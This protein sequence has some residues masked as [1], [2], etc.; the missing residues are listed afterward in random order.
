MVLGSRHRICRWVFAC[1]GLLAT[2]QA[3]SQA[4]NVTPEN[5]YKKRIQVSETIQPLGENPFGEQ[6]SLYNGALSFEQKDINAPGIGPDIDIIRSFSIPNVGINAAFHD[7]HANAF[8]DWALEVPHIETLSAPEKNVVNGIT[9]YQWFLIDDFYGTQRCSGLSAGPDMYVS[10]PGSVVTYNS[11]DWWH[12]YQLIIPG[13]GRQDLLWRDASNTLSPQMTAADGSTMSFPI[14]TKQHWSI[15]CLSQTANGQPGQGYLAVS[16]DGTKYW[17]DWLIYKSADLVVNQA[18]GGLKRRTLMMMVSKVQDRFGNTVNYSYDSNGNLTSIQASDGRQIALNYV[19]WQAPTSDPGPSNSPPTTYTSFRISSITLQP[20]SGAP[21]TWNYTYGSDPT[22]PRLTAAQLPDGV[23]VWSFN[24]SGLP[25]TE[26]DEVITYGGADTCQYTLTPNGG[27][28][29]TAVL[30]HPSGLVGTFTVKTVIRGRSYVPESCTGTSPGMRPRVYAESAIQQKAFSGAG[31]PNETWTYSYSPSNESWAKD[32]STGCASTV[33]TDVIDPNHNAAR[34]TFSNKFDATESLL[35]QTDYYSGAVGGT[36][37]R[38]EI[39]SYANPAGGPWPAMLGSS[40]QVVV[41]TAQMGQLIPI[42]QRTLQQDGDIYTW[43]AEAFDVYA[44]ATMTKRYNSIAGQGA[45]E[46][47]MSYLYDLPHWVLGLPQ[48]TDNV[49]T[50]EMESLN[51]YNLANVTLKSRARFGQTLMSYAFDGQGQLASFIDGK[52]HTTTLSNY[53]RGIPQSIGYPDNT[54]QSLVV[55]D[56]GQIS[57]I[58]DQAGNTTNYSYD[59][60]GRVT[61]ISYPANDTVSW[62]SKQFTYAPVATSER[63]ISGLHWDRTITIGNARTA[64][65]FDAM[66]RPV[67]SDI[68]IIGVSNSDITNTTAYDWKGKAT[69][70]SYPVVGA[71]DIGS[72]STGTH[73]AYDAL[74]RLI[75]T[76]EDSELGVLTTTT[77]YIANAGQQV[78]DPN[79]NVTT[80]YH[81]VFD[82]PSYQYPIQIN[83]AAGISQS[84]TRDIYGNPTA[85][86][87]SGVYGSEHDSITKTLMYDSYHRLCR[88]AEPES[89]SM[90]MAYDAANNLVWSAQGQSI[91]DGTCGQADVA[92]SAQTVRNYDA[93]NRVLTITPPSGTQSTTYFYDARG[94]IKTAV[95]GIATQSF[96]Y[97]TR[98]LLTSQTL[99]IAGTSSTWGV[100]YNYDGYA[101][102]NAIGYPISNGVS[103]GVAYNPDPLGRAT[104]VGSYVTGITY[105]PNGQVAGFNYSNG[106]SYVAQQNARRLL[107]NF[108]YGAGS[109][110]SVSEDFIYD[111]NGNITNVNDLV[112][113]QRTKVFGYDALNRLTSATATN[114]YGTESYTYDALN[115]L[116]SRLTGGNQLT[117]N[118]DASNRLA[119]VTQGA[120]VTTTYG[121]DASGNRNSLSSGSTITQYGFDAE[122]QLLQI[123]GLESYAYDS[124]GRRIVKTASSGTATYYFY[125]QAGQLMFQYEPATAKATNYIYLGTKSIARHASNNS[126]IIG[127]IDGISTDGSGNAT[128]VGWACSTNLA[129]STNVDLYIGG[130]VDGGGTFIGR[131]SASQASESGVAMACNVSGGSYRFAIPIST[132]IRSQYAGQAIYVYGISPVGNANLAIS[133]SGTNSVPANPAAPVAPSSVTTTVASDLTSVVATWPSVSAATSYS[134]QYRINSGAWTQNASL[135]A[136]SFILNSPADGN[137]QFQVQACNLGGC[138]IFA[139]STAVGVWH[140]TAAPA[141]SAPGISSNGSYTVSWVAVSAA[142]SYTLQQQTNGG[143]WTTIQTSNATS[144]AA[145]G[146]GTGSYAYRVQGCNG[147]GC[148]PWS[149]IVTTTV[150]YPP[151]SAPSVSVP[152]SSN[153]GSYAVNW[154]SVSGATSYTLQE[155]VNGGGW[156]TVQSSGATSWIASGKGNGTYGYRAQACNVGGCGPWSGTGSITVTYPPSGAPSVSALGSSTNGSYTVS[157]SGVGGANSYVLQEQVNSGGWSAVQNSGATSWSTSGKGNG[158]YGYHVQACNVGGCGPW[159]SV[160]NVGVTLIPATPTGGTATWVSGPYYKPVVKYS[161]NATAWATSYNVQESDPNSGGW[162]SFYSGTGTSASSLFLVNGNVYFQVRACS[163][164]G[165]SPWSASA[166]ITLSSGG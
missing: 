142:A 82:E 54:S 95:S 16:P 104:Q 62:Y 7:Y 99:S 72:V 151:S 36:P 40:T 47:Q 60:V 46:E 77:A 131:Y 13:Q 107:S 111:A 160:A 121:Y 55:D 108:S 132:A 33:T 43:L 42:N 154:G 15:A 146:E 105:F 158:T 130:P 34:Y 89:G 116:R 94:N 166:S 124:A 109:A 67:L 28:T 48:E 91:T 79:R 65:Y 11:Q 84:I 155:Q 64:T 128:L 117:F 92:S 113:G 93:M 144:W 22:I 18:G 61:Q 96:N 157:W 126:Q 45:I 73:H 141:V 139:I 118:Y 102:V 76:Q 127:N 90:V 138:S 12:G 39:N 97:N 6:V 159:S 83:A 69:F 149:N 88:T 4:T 21:R 148:G 164:S 123:P 162:V 110:L 30:I 114:L 143:S 2:C 134:L 57:S 19:Q 81:Q 27:A 86:T 68:S 20:S 32:C 112:N 50:G 150:V 98:N 87:Q 5:E 129:Q 44:Q 37:I 135:T 17:M 35:L 26:P 153:N 103:E 156:S 78:T 80:I 100:A 85:I 165:C 52:N 66:L 133:N 14:V 59:P 136:T 25:A 137:Y 51:T 9:T 147:G 53:K 122:N 106:S 115:N 71:S 23:S 29:G 3:W 163:A 63:G 70:T 161:W 41:N 10:V 8:V 74:E 119:S 1:L 125:D 49:T 24:M 56:F 31:I 75:Q 120:N 38:S 152:G 140:V 101:H 58:S 145:S